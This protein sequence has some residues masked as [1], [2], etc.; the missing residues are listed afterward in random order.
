ML[1]IISTH[2]IQYQVPI[3]KHLA[4]RENIKFEVWYLTSHGIEPT[5]DIQFGKTIMWDIDLLDGYPYCFSKVHCPKKLTNFW[6]AKLPKD[7]RNR[8]KSDEITQI[9]LL[10][11]NVRAFIE[12]VFVAWRN[13]KKIWLRAESNDLKTNSY[14]KTKIKSLLLKIFFLNIDKFLT[15]GKANKRLYESFGVKP[16]KLHP[17][18]YCI[19]NERFAQ[20]ANVNLKKRDKLRSYW[21]INNNSFCVLFV[22]KFITK[23]NP[24]DIIKALKILNNIHVLKDFHILFVGAGELESELKKNTNIIFDCEKKIDNHN[25]SNYL[26]KASFTG[27]VNQ[28]KISEAYTAADLLVLPSD[29]NETWGL[30]VNEAM[31]SGLPCVVSDACGSSEDLVDTIDPLLRYPLGDIQ[32]LSNSIKHASENLPS[33]KKLKKIIDSYDFFHTVDTIEKLWSISKEK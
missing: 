4:K 28:S 22:G 1:V 11:W 18:P 5:Y 30:V 24:G 16:D 27:F 10:G 7:F 31:A 29:A 2:P 23:K 15:I 6:S 25:A 21:K 12:V 32:S 3:W 33:K 14:L 13:R 17:A 8:L 26:P 19:E 9:L 20:Q